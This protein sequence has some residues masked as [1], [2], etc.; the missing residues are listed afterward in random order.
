MYKHYHTRLPD[1]TV[2][3]RTLPYLQF[4]GATKYT[5][6]RGWSA[7]AGGFYRSE[8][9]IAQQVFRPVG[10]LNLGLH[11]K[12]LKDKGSLTLYGNDVLH[13]WVPT[14]YVYMPGVVAHFRNTFDRREISLTFTYTFGKKVEKAPEHTTGAQSERSRL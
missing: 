9:L 10:R 3:D 4:S 8:A 11:K 12:V 2:L 1:T 5:L 14:K 6:G 7:E 13:T